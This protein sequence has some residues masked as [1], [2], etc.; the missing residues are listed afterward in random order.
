MVWLST[1]RG[2]WCRLQEFERRIEDFIALL[3]LIDGR[4]DLE[5]G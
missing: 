2:K 5:D 3:D 4:P 1:C